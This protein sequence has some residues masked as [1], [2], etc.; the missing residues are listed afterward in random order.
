MARNVGR[1]PRRRPP[2]QK[3]PSGIVLGVPLVLLSGLLLARTPAIQ[4]AKH[5][6]AGV[7][8]AREQPLAQLERDAAT[9]NYAR[10]FVAA[11]GTRMVIALRADEAA[12]PAF[13][14]TR[15]RLDRF[16]TSAR[17]AR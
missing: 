5:G 15:V 2:E 14:D 11:N 1:K 10:S 9:R 4:H 17:A 7:P 3:D 12:Q 6:T 8:P 13:D 16:S